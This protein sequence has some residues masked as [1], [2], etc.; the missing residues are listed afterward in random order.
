[1]KAWE[2]YQHD[3]AE[4]LRELGFMAVVNASLTEPN[5]A[6]HA[7]DVSA[8]RTLAGVDLLWVVECKLWNRRVPME[9]V[10]VL[11][12]IVDGVGADRGLLMSEEGFQSGALRM[13]VQKNI[14]LSGL[15]DLRENAAEELRAARVTATEKRLMRLALRTGRDLNP[16]A[17]Q[18]PRML[19]A[20][21]KQLRTEDVEEFAGRR[22]AV[23]LMD[24]LTE[25]KNRILDLAADYHLKFLTHPSELK[26][27]WRSGIDSDVMDGVATA[28]H[29]LTQALYQARLG[30]WPVFV[31][32]KDRTIKLA[33]STRQILDVVE[34]ALD[35]LEQKV[36]EQEGKAARGEKAAT[37]TVPEPKFA[38]R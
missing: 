32:D 38:R 36:T 29:Y 34:P 31:P 35:E 28:V 16:S 37:E 3:T 24:G 9:K 26:L 20:L 25:V 11:K 21:A 1:M 7:A 6:V 10:G 15:A 17:L 5:G 2:R 19:V 12:A 13:A 22:A 4:L 27:Q 8:R 33:W 30:E 18:M 23:D 14:T